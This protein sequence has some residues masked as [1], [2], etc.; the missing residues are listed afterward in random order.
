M[1]AN[2]VIYHSFMDRR[3]KISGSETKNFITHSMVGN[4]SI[5]ILASVRLV[6]KANRRDVIKPNDTC[7]YWGIA[8][9]RRKPRPKAQNFLIK[10]Q[11][12]HQAENKD[13][14]KEIKI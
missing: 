10:Q 14:L 11:T 7:T 4:M 2:Q 9:Q 12:L 13:I 8:L 6:L 3:Q 1:Q 5:S